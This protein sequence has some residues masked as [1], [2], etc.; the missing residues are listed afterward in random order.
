MLLYQDLRRKWLTIVSGSKFH[1]HR[2]FVD[3]GELVGRR[4]GESVKTSMGQTL[5]VFKPRAVDTV[6]AFER[7]T[8]ILYPKDIGYAL[9]QL[10]VEPGHRVVE[11]GTGSGAMTAAL[12][13]AVQPGGHVYSYETRPE[14]SEVARSN[15]EK[16]G[17]SSLVTLHNKDPSGGFNETGV[18]AAVLDLGDPWRMTGAAWTALGGGGMLAGFTPT[19]NQLEK[20]AESLRHESFIVL[21]AVEVLLRQLRTDAGKLRPESRMVGHTAYITIARKTLGKESS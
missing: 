7:P 2:G 19:F 5:W 17:V 3:L 15:L 11:V 10:G 9:Y 8:Q 4:Y 6:E 13:R 18:D 1:T 16:T 12:A 21:E 14:F 20:L